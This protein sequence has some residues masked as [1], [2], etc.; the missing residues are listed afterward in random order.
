VALCKSIEA[1]RPRRVSFMRNTSPT[2]YTA[3]PVTL[4]E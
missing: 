4:P 2:A 3:R 1:T